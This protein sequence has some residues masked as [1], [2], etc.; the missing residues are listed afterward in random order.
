M[1]KRKIGAATPSPRETTLTM[2]PTVIIA[3]L[4]LVVSYD[5]AVE[6]ASGG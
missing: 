2:F 3:L 6:T 5:S 4:V 1:I